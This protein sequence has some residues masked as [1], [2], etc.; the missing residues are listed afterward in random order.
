MAASFTATAAAAE[1]RRGSISG[2][3]YLAALVERWDSTQKFANA[4]LLKDE[5]LQTLRRN[6]AEESAES[7]RT[8]KRFAAAGA[9]A[10]VPFV[11]SPSIDARGYSI[12]GCNAAL[13]AGQATR[14]AP[15]LAALYNAGACLFGLSNTAELGQ[16][17]LQAHSVHGL[18][19][20]VRRRRIV[21]ACDPA[22]QPYQGARAAVDTCNRYI[23]PL[24][25]LILLSLVTVMQPC[26]TQ[27]VAGSG[28]S[29]SAALVAAHV[30]PFAVGVDTSSGDVRV[31]AALCGVVGFRPSQ[32]R[33]SRAGLL[34]LSSTLD[35]VGLMAR[36]V[37]D[38]QLVDA[39]IAASAGA[40]TRPAP[41][42]AAPGV[43]AGFGSP[44][45]DGSGPADSSSSPSS[46]PS[47]AELALKRCSDS[48]E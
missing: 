35:T 38:V 23:M 24:R 22:L 12:H 21:M 17:G 4:L 2:F 44:R 43:A 34:T 32:G 11:V 25:A 10:S 5:G 39:V 15:V 9:L 7:T 28:C 8:G 37:E 33:Y 16:P 18:V 41:Q 3:Q 19:K 48:D 29:G 13:N 31:P 26:S 14:D 30:V 47:A 6:I 45:A 42:P 1:I 36:T 46:G 40:A 20:N 27:S